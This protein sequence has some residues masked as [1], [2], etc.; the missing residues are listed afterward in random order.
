MTHSQNLSS[1][2]PPVRGGGRRLFVSLAF[3]NEIEYNNILEGIA[4]FAKVIL[5]YYLL[6]KVIYI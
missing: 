2:R 5:P 6:R 3:T 1:G 4:Y